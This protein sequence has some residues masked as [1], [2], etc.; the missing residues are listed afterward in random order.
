MLF[1]AVCYCIV[2]SNVGAP[3]TE[4]LHILECDNV[5][6][7]A[8]IVQTVKG[9]EGTTYFQVNKKGDKLYSFISEKCDGEKRGAAVVF[10]IKDNRI[11]E[12]TKL[13]SLPCE[14]PCH[15][16]ISPDENVF[17]FAAYTTA[18]WGTFPLAL[19][20]VN[21]LRFDLSSKGSFSARLADKGMGPRAD[22]QK[23]A[24]AHCA[25]FT[26]NGKK[27]GIID[28]GCDA[29][30]FYDFGGEQSSLVAR[31]VSPLVVKAEP[32]DG[33]RHA[34][35]SKDGRHLFVVNEL[36][37]SVTSYAYDG[38][39]KF[40]RI[41]KWSMLPKGTDPLTTKAAAIKLTKDGKILM[42]SNRGCDSIAFFEVKD[43][44]ELELKNIAP[45]KGRFP[46]DFELMPGERFMV[47]GH[48]MSD[49]IQVYSF[50][51]AKCTLAPVG[52]PI[53]C[54]RPLCFKFIPQGYKY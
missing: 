32:G 4:A 28:L 39:E 12:M 45:L 44:G 41:G 46:R 24:Y 51:R 33:P 52:D 53:P 5:T 38:K 49:E 20:G 2:G 36:S 34:I 48:K 22:R 21:P 17:A 13:S 29:I 19:D 25:F 6:G 14:V 10:D 50:D 8:K 1:P 31:V 15:V 9:I 30:F 54:H 42:A 47:V 43:N 26:P 18:T 37:S 40:T 27:L 3:G 11:G 35:F 16:G 23:K 7:A